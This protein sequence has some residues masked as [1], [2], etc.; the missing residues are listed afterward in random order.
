MSNLPRMTSC[1][2]SARTFVALCFCGVSFASAQTDLQTFTSPEGVFR[3]KYSR[4]L[5]RCTLERSQESLWASSWA[6]ADACM[7]PAGVCD[8]AEGSASTIACFAYPKDK[9]KEKPTFSAAAFFIA[10]VLEGTQEACLAGSRHWLIPSAET[11]KIN[12]VTFRLFRISDSWTSGGQTGE[13]YRVF[14]NKKCYEVGVQEA[15]T[16]SAAYDPGTIKE[17][18]KQDQ[19]EVHN[20]LKQAL[21]S[22]RF[23]K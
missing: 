6:P 19:D 9:F 12:A 1:G 10:E 16:S 11:T 17:F 4:T 7:S 3:F 5:V 2:S 21:D 20:R 14:H 13:I 15:H 18:T 22:F 23:L 8:D